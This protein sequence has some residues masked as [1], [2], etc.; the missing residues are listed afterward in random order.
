L[1]FV[2]ILNTRYLESALL[3]AK[4][5]RSFEETA[6][7]FLSLPDS[8][9][10]KEYLINKLD[11]LSA[12]DQT[13]TSLLIIWIIELI[14]KD[15]TRAFCRD[16]P[17]Q[18]RIDVL[19][20]EFESICG[21][22]KIKSIVSDCKSAIYELLKSH[23]NADFLCCFA[24][25]MSDF[26][27]AIE[28]YIQLQQYPDALRLMRKHK[29]VQLAYLFSPL[30]FREKPEELIQVL[31]D[32][33]PNIDYSRLLP[34]LVWCKDTDDADQPD[35]CS[36]TVHYTQLIRYLEHCVER[37]QT[38]DQTVFNYLLTI[39]AEISPNKLIQLCNQDNERLVGQ[40][41][42]KYALS[43]CSEKKLHR[44]CVE[45][46]SLMQLYDEAVESA[47]RIDVDLAKQIADR[48]EIEDEHRRRLWMRVAE[49][50]IQTDNDHFKLDDLLREC[51]LLRIDDVLQYLPEVS[52]IDYFKQAVTESLHEFRQE[53]QSLQE[54][55][56]EVSECSDNIQEQ[57]RSLR[58][59]HCVLRAEDCCA[60]CDRQLLGNEFVAFPCSHWFHLPCLET[61]LLVEAP[62]KL[63]HEITANKAQLK[64]IER[65]MASESI[66]SK[67]S[68]QQRIS[69]Q[70]N[71]LLSSEC[72]YCDEIMIATIDRPFAVSADDKAGWD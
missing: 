25:L 68:K 48:P 55:M 45:I 28:Q 38:S 65:S 40:F 58:T 14:M 43:V 20:I 32:C 23:S 35:D 37:L 60:L 46:Y 54:D 16:E 53:L 27:I 6:L 47:L 4:S 1:L 5:N 61:H 41:D 64:F 59:G 36:S 31:I 70:L 13:Q 2:W 50:V 67:V 19:K 30:L 17:D 11:S 9:I 69:Q 44:A 51:P 29:D 15:V 66:E 42:L 49:H 52:T 21:N 34:T 24:L 56:N 3:F 57:L 8:S 7:K 22:E 18:D 71:D 26:D 12:K 10:L 33:F 63:Q 72:P 39:Y 62:V